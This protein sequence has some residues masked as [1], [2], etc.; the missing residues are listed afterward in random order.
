MSGRSPNIQ[1]DIADFT[2]IIVAAETAPVVECLSVDVNVEHIDIS[3][4]ALTFV[5]PSDFRNHYPVL[6]TPSE[7]VAQRSKIRSI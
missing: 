7:R 5:S 6:P 1:L 3:Q 4:L 2:S